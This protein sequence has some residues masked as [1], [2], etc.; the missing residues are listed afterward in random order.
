MTFYISTHPVHTRRWITRAW[1][2]D[3]STLPLGVNV[4]DEDE[5]FV[6]TAYIPG[7]TAEDVNIQ[8]LDDVISLEGEIKHPEAEYLINELPSGPFRRALRLPASLDA[9]K[10]E[11]QIANGM[12][13][14][15]LP[16][17]ESARPKTIKVN[18]K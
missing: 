16:K 10:A 15:R 14:L 7:L 1:D 6:L 2:Q 4:R 8:I 18:V 17:A 3:Q 11:A 13:T 12:L 5:A 9:D